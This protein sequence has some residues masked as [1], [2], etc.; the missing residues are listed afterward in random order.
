MEYAHHAFPFFYIQLGSSGLLEPAMNVL[1]E[2]LGDG[3]IKITKERGGGGQLKSRFQNTGGEEQKDFPGNLLSSDDQYD[4]S[5]SA[6]SFPN[7]LR[8]LS[9]HPTSAA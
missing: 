9:S 8:R 6:P 4:T 5:H 2:Y 3:V 1:A 7:S